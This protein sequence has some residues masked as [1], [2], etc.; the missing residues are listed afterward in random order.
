M[1]SGRLLSDYT[2][3]HEEYTEGLKDF[4]SILFSVKL[5]VSSA[6]LCDLSSY[7]EALSALICVNL[8]PTKKLP[9]STENTQ[10][11]SEISPCFFTL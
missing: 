4:S 2:E 9:E 11:V 5:R 1:M 10:R 7:Q 6:L 8:R 3:I